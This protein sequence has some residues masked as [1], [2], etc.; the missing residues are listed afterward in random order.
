[1]AA[2]VAGLPRQIVRI[3]MAA[4]A[5]MLVAKI[6][7]LLGVLGLLGL[8]GLQQVRTLFFMIKLSSLVNRKKIV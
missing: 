8:Q 5:G 4:Y 1:M 2:V 7:V 3:V 6:L